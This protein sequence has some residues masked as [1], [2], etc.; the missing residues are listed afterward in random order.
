[1]VVWWLS[2][3]VVWCSRFGL[4]LFC[5]LAR[6]TPEGVGG[7]GKPGGLEARK[8]RGLEARRPGEG[9]RGAVG[10]SREPID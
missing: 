9:A 6:S 8:P 7:F 1:M 5:Y 10:K 2:G 4:V 3:L